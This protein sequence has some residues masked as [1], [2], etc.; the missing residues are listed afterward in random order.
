MVLIK[1]I[2]KKSVSKA[3]KPAGSHRFALFH[4]LNVTI[5]VSEHEWIAAVNITP[6]LKV[7][8]EV[9]SSEMMSFAESQTVYS[10]DGGKYV[11]SGQFVLS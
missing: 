10:H 1:V 3:W 5:I 7:S 4:I 11:N 6:P 2:K 9:F 8:P